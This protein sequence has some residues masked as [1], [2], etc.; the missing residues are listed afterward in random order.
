MTIHRLLDDLAAAGIQVW[1]EGGRLRFRTN[2]GALTERWRARLGAAKEALLAHFAAPEPAAGALSPTPLQQAYW[3]GEQAF[4]QA[5]TAAHV[6]QEF[7]V[8]VL[9]PDGLEAAL[10]HL[11]AR[12]PMLNVR[13]A[14]DGTQAFADRTPFAVRRHDFS[15]LDRDGERA[16]LEAFRTSVGDTLPPLS[17]GPPFL[18]AALRLRDGWHVG[19]AFRLFAFDGPS[20][21]IFFED[22]ARLLAGEEPPEPAPDGYRRFLAAEAAS[23]RSPKRAS[24]ERYWFSRLAELGVAPELPMAA[25]GGATG[26]F[27]RIEGRLPPA[28]W[29]RLGEAARAH[30]VGINAVLCAVFAA[31]VRRWSATPSFA[32]NLLVSGRGPR[33]AGRFIGNCS[34]TLLLACRDPGAASF[35]DAALALQQQI[36]RDLACAS[37]SGVE[38]LRAIQSERGGAAQP[39][40]P[41]VFS[42]FI[43]LESRDDAVSAPVP[44]WRLVAGAMSTPQVLLDHQVYLDRGTLAYN[45][46]ASAG[47]FP[48]GMVEA[49]AEYYRAALTA[50]ARDPGAWTRPPSFPLPDSQLR[51]RRKANATRQSLP[52]GLLHQGFFD[53]AT[54]RPER[55]ALIAWD[56]TLTYGE[57]RAGALAVAGALVAAGVAPGDRVGI[58]AAKGWRQIVAVLG[59]L[60]AGGCYVPLDTRAPSARNAEILR[61]AGARFVLGDA[62]M[63]VADCV[64]MDIA[65]ATRAEPLGAP[66]PVPADQLAYIIFTSGSTGRPKGVMIEH[67]AA[68]NTIQDLLDRFGLTA[69]DRVLGLSE[70][71]FD[72]SVFDIF[73]LLTAGGALVLPRPSDFPTP[74]E[75]VAL[76][77]RHRIT[78][79]N[80]VPQL[81]A[82]L[83][84]QA[85]GEA[86]DL[87]AQLRLVMLSG[88]WIPLALAA[89][90]RTLA[91]AGRLVS[92]G[93]ATEA[94]IWSNW[95]PVDRVDPDW[96]SV[97]YGFPLAN[98]EFHV[99]DEAMAPCPVWVPGEL[100][101]GGVG[102]AR[103]YVGAAD[104]TARAFVTD[105]ATGRR[106]YKTGDLGRYWPDGTLE[107]L[108]RRDFQVKINGFRI[109]L[110]EVEAVLCRHPM[111]EA[112]LAVAAGEGGGRRLCA[113]V[114]A[115]A[116][117]VLDGERIRAHA[118]GLLPPYMVPIQV[119]QLDRMPLSRNGKVDRAAIAG[120]FQDA[121]QPQAADAPCGGLETD[122]HALWAE[123][124]GCG[125]VPPTVD[126]FSLGGNSL[127][128]VLLMNAIHRRFGRRLEPSVIFS[129]GTI[130]SLAA[131]LAQ[132]GTDQPAPLVPLNRADGGRRI[133]AVHPVGGGIACYR[134][135]A[136]RLAP[137]CALLALPARP[138][139]PLGETMADLARP[140]L[141]A[142]RQALAPGEPAVLAGWSFGGMLAL[143]MARMLAAEGH[144][145]QVLMIDSYRS[146]GAAG[147]GDDEAR[148]LFRRDLRRMGHDD[149][150]RELEGAFAIFRRN[151]AALMAHDPAPVA[152]PVVHVQAADRAEDF[153]GL[154]PYDGPA[155]G[156]HVLPGDHFTLLEGESAAAIADLLRDM[157]AAVR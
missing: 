132:E 78:V 56:R 147:L 155:V 34:N 91:P 51:A 43:G 114:V 116:G 82:L 146:A 42:S 139:G 103:G 95:Y 55:I 115:A 74:E 127:R 36:Y 101:I 141:A 94:S 31:T 120:L 99:L 137:D 123:V 54:A 134:P 72:L 16:A 49:M 27:G 97:P 126:F 109:E 48:A 9:D 29:G 44:G 26:R 2:G 140:H 138:A 135:L 23:R 71:N 64:A 118:A 85:G 148:G 1:E 75:W 152:V 83:L 76:I 50:L 153:P 20:V 12:H 57:V 19:C 125:T 77:R 17:D 13:V 18:V 7:A 131:L 107:F 130:R 104:L 84:D 124:L 32:L 6:Y 156:R 30:D 35:R 37:V 119:R 136:D 4:Y 21:Q 128:A 129:H 154:R 38:V 143:E 96:R 121:G 41:V 90:V 92:L 89:Q 40:A 66:V 15:G 47:A 5:A 59:V 151:Y 113:V 63:A 25:G 45:W 3:I 33:S 117:C 87:L 70:L 65:A 46:D 80:T 145:V 67:R 60:L 88:D 8:A 11:I 79:W 98:Q 52:G 105:P 149:A 108:G 68:V 106:L 53:A 69:D 10:R 112:A 24:D 86:A 39:L 110:E 61:Q 28:D 100:H 93:G 111:V 102:V 142:L 58:V 144:R 14:E 157:A 22:L 133:F 150:D 81:L 62:P 73:G 122:L